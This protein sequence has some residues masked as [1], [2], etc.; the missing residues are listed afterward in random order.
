MLE[1][2]KPVF[3]V[4]NEKV[5]AEAIGKLMKKTKLEKATFF[6]IREFY[7]PVPE[8][9]PSDWLACHPTPPQTFTVSV[10]YIY[11]EI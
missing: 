2:A 11:L 1:E 7:L 10:I 3:I 5:R 6:S 8:P 4:P 9:G